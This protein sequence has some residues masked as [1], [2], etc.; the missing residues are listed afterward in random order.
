[1]AKRERKGNRKRIKDKGRT[2]TSGERGVERER[3]E[4]GER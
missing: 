3:K 4:G 2:E 1:M